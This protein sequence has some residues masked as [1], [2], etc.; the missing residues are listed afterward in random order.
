M[1]AVLDGR[2]GAGRFGLRVL[3]G[4]AV[5]SVATLLVALIWAAD[6]EPVPAGPAEVVRVGVAA[7]QSV[8]GYLDSSRGELAALP[9]TPTGVQ[10]WALVSLVAYY[11][12]DRLPAVLA[13]SAVAQVYARVPLGAERTPVALIPASRLPD[14]V[15]AGM[16]ATAARR[17]R[18]RA[19][20]LRLAGDLRGDDPNVRR[21]RG[22]Y[23]SAAALAAAEAQAYRARCACV[24]AAVVRGDPAALHRLAY[25]A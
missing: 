23:G 5:A 2:P 7:G 1:A 10:T 22:A 24:F 18:E 15:V 14:D 13:G 3:T 17:E 9:R 16:L 19:D 4:L 11:P 8:P 6:P 12:P 25:R 21:L 20:F